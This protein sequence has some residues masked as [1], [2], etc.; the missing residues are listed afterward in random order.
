MTTNIAMNILRNAK[1]ETKILFDKN[2][3]LTLTIIIN[4]Q[5]THTFPATSRESRMVETSE[6]R[7]LDAFFNN[8]TYIIVDGTMQ[9]YRPS[10]YRGFVQ[11]DNALDA[12]AD[13][14]GVEKFDKSKYADPVRGLYNQIRGKRNSDVFLGGTWDKFNLDVESLGLG[15]EFENKL[16]YRYSPF[17]K[18]IQ[19]SFEVKRLVCE[20]GMI[21]NSPF[22]TFE[23]PVIDDWENNLQIVSSQ[24][25]P[26]I[27]DILRG[28]FESMSKDNSR[29]NV[30]TV[31]KVHEI[32]QSRFFEVEDGADKQVFDKLTRFSEVTN[33]TKNLGQ[34]YK[35]SSLYDTKA[36]VRMDSH[37]T[38]FDVYNI[39][40]EMGSHVGRAE[41]TD[42]EINSTANK[43]IFD[44]FNGKKKIKPT[45]PV[46]QESDHRRKFFGN[47]N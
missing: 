25:Q 29:A 32:I 24:L 2:G 26:K 16:V 31:E 46:S 3:K 40:T 39:L 7:V 9:D 8:G 37:L 10:T 23:V 19:T 1:V 18:N 12:L 36:K 14:I 11:T 30:A 33:I 13:I 22:V 15:G 44:D 42:F 4:N 6:Q 28:R 35:E 21:A 5:Y 43:I 47:S 27:N 20:N 17:S 41:V 45:I 38:Q 34:F